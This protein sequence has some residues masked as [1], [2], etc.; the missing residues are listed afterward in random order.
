MAADSKDVVRSRFG[1]VLSYLTATDS[2]FA[3]KLTSSDAEGR[4]AVV[5]VLGTDSVHE[6]TR[7]AR[8]QGGHVTV[9]AL[10]GREKAAIQISTASLSMIAP[11]ECAGGD[12]HVPI[13]RACKVADLL[14]S[15]PSGSAITFRLAHEE[16]TLDSVTNE[17][18]EDGAVLDAV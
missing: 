3:S 18:V 7:L 2:E 14:D 12:H 13:T 5:P 17:S 11:A 6:M 9:V 4:R 1:A 16:V 15:L 10:M 8:Q